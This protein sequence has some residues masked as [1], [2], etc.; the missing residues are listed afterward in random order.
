FM[1]T[2]H[3]TEKYV[4]TPYDEADCW[5]LTRRVMAEQFSYHFPA[6]VLAALEAGRKDLRRISEPQE[7][8]LVMLRREGRPHI[9]VMVSSDRMLHTGRGKDAVVE[10]IFSGWHKVTGFY[11][12]RNGAGY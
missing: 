5:Q 9:G 10:R 8:D 4:G 11:R 1:A 7:G 6:D 3:W 12:V 2:P